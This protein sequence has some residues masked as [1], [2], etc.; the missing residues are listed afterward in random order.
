MPCDPVDLPA[1]EYEN[2]I[3][4]GTNREY[5]EKKQAFC[6]VSQSV[7]AQLFAPSSRT[8]LRPIS[9]GTESDDEG[10]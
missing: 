5:A 1:V 6:D 7:V 10:L 2:D 9:G 8:L 4:Y 3:V